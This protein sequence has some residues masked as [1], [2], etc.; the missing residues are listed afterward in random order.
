MWISY[1]RS[2]GKERVGRK[3]KKK[4]SLGVEIRTATKSCFNVLAENVLRGELA[5]KTG[6]S[7][8]AAATSTEK[9]LPRMSA[10]N[11]NQT[12][13]EIFSHL[14]PR[15]SP[16]GSAAHKPEKTVRRFK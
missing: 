1:F 9:S 2:T 7:R 10:G 12:E 13:V 3:E 14:T 8:R 4:C 11:F 16:R 6:S 15:F 5:V